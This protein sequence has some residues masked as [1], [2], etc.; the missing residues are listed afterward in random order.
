MYVVVRQYI[1][2]Y[3]RKAVKN[4]KILCL[5]YTYNV[6][7]NATYSVVYIRMHL[8][9]WHFTSYTRFLCSG[10]LDSNFATTRFF[11]IT[12]WR[13]KTDNGKFTSHRYRL[14]AIQYVVRF[15]VFAK[16]AV[17]SGRPKY[18]LLIIDANII[19]IIPIVPITSICIKIQRT[20]A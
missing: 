13:L 19:I 7:Y 3:N 9:F 2:H 6:T 17:T 1:Y 4:I 18:L 16:F 11:P 8:A 12:R 20:T 14:A 5:S 10:E 15:D